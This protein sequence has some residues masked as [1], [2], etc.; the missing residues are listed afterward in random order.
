MSGNK[1]EWSE[2][3][4]FLRLLGDGKLYAADSALNKIPDLFFPI[5]K[6]LREEAKISR[7]Y[8]LN[9]NVS[10]FDSQSKKKLLEIPTAEFVSNS[11]VLLKK[12]QSV[13]GS[14]F[15]VP[16]ISEFLNK[17]DCNSLKAKSSDK[18]DISIVVHDERTGN[19][20][21]LGFS[22]KSMLGQNSTLFNPGNTTNFIYEITG[23]NKSKLDV[24]EINKI[25]EP[26]KIKNRLEHLAKFRFS[27][28]FH[29]IQSENLQDNLNLIDSR[30]SELIAY[31]LYYN[32][33]EDCS[34]KLSDLLNVLKEKNPLGFGPGKEQPFYEYKI[35]NFL[36][37]S[38]LGM[39]PSSV[40][41]GEYDATGGIIIV[42]QDGEIVCYHIY[43]RSEF[44]Q[45]L[46]DNTKLEQASTTRYSF[47]DVYEEKGRYFIKLN[48]QVRFC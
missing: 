12:L 1:G 44:Q 35:K 20:P 18:S 8:I 28:Q 2:V 9:G 17:I 31:M 37:D 25:T 22:I 5:I 36:T 40:W 3:Y 45:Y 26:P 38:A 46:L 4:V 23:I 34:S 41:K 29:R 16:E 27:L 30:M 14:S 13:S 11:K 32:Y 43:N 7:E 48:L 33:V 10:I 19:D 21:L 42:K 47:G 24:K 15:D 6:I 39:T